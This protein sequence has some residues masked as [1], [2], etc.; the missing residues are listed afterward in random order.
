MRKKRRSREFKK[1]SQVI[2]IEQARKQRLDRKAEEK[3]REEE[4]IRYAASQE[5]AH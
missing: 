5:G 3:R 2:D 4:R 1:N